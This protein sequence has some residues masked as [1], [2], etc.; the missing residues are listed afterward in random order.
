ML[1]GNF[2]FLKLCTYCLYQQTYSIIG[3]VVNNL[4]CGPCGLCH[5][6]LNSASVVIKQHRQY[7]IS[8]LQTQEVDQDWPHA[9]ICHLLDSRFLE[10]LILG[11]MQFSNCVNLL[12]NLA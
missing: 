7:T 4:F 6:Y 1:S 9:I 3:Q 12:L 11:L 8:D 5:N 10:T 2:W